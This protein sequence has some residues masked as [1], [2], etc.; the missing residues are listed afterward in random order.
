V[1]HF[2]ISIVNPA[3]SV[4]SPRQIIKISPR[5]VVLKEQL[6]Y[7]QRNTFYTSADFVW[8]RLDRAPAR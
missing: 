7:S 1:A 8:G 6:Q 4:I 3:H 5:A 2:V